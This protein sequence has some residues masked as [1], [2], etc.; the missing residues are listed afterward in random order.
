MK[1]NGMLF[2][3]IGTTLVMVLL[4]LAVAAPM[5]AT[6]N[7]TL[8]ALPKSDDFNTCG[9]NNSIWPAADQK[10]GTMVGIDGAFTIQFHIAVHDPGGPK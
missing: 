7:P 10:G 4:A 1:P 8:A 2:Y 6:A 3:R 5:T 9:L